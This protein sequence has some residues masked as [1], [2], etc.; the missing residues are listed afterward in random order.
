MCIKVH[1]FVYKKIIMKRTN[2]EIDK[3]LMEKAMRITRIRTIKGVVNYS[4]GQV[5]EAA[6]RSELSKLKGKVHWEGNL[7]DMRGI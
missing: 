2:V 3:D 4:L 6:K 7:D 5:V 1:N